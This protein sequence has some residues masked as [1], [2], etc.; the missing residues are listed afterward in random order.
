MT[1]LTIS[2]LKLNSITATQGMNF[3]QQNQAKVERNNNNTNDKQADVHEMSEAIKAT[4]TNQEGNNTK[5]MVDM[6][7]KEILADERGLVRTAAMGQKSKVTCT[8]DSV[9]MTIEKSY[10]E[11]SQ[12]LTIKIN[13]NGY[14][15][16]EVKDMKP[17]EK[18]I[19]AQ[20]DE[21]KRE[22][23]RSKNKGGLQ[24]VRNGV[25]HYKTRGRRTLRVRL[26]RF[27][28]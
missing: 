25:W 16:T 6:K 3:Q 10:D 15:K 21:Y 28:R 12:K 22:E 11:K 27:G 19:K 18:D 26:P 14:N 7:L 20:K 2:P 1:N 4:Q 24:E 23:S 5:N 8:M 9:Q 13:S 17:L